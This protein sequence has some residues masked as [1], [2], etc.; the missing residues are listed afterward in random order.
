M[1][2]NIHGFIEVKVSA[3]HYWHG[4]VREPM[5]DRNY[6]LFCVLANVRCYGVP[7]MNEPRGLPKDISCE[8]EELYKLNDGDAHSCSFWTAKEFLS[9][10]WGDIL[11]HDWL[12]FY[13]IMTMLVS[14]Y[15]EDNVRFVFFFD[16]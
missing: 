6:R 10:T 9:Y 3:G 7:S 8:M 5:L 13:N 12:I 1:G 14:S 15:G 16:N 2:C 11:D 4:W